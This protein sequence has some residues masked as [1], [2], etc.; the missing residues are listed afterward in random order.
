MTEAREGIELT[1][2][3]LVSAADP[4]LARGVEAPVALGGLPVGAGPSLMVLCG[5]PLIPLGAE[6]A[7]V[8]EVGREPR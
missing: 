5:A 1:E 3:P 4:P 2:E 7:G 6:A 8:G